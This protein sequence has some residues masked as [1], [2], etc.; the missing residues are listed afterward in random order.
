MN[1]KA[2]GLLGVLLGALLGA[3]GAG[4]AAAHDSGVEVRI[5]ARR[6]DDGRVE[7]ALRERGGE[8]I[9]PVRRY[10]PA[11][12]RGVWLH[13]SWIEAGAPATA[14]TLGAGPDWRSV[15]GTDD[16]TGDPRAEIYSRATRWAGSEYGVPELWM[17]CYRGEFDLW[18][19]WADIIAHDFYASEGRGRFSID[20]E[21]VQDF[22]WTESPGR[23]STF[24]VLPEWLAGQVAA[25]S[26][27]VFRIWD[28]EGLEYTAT[29]PTA[30]F[31]QASRVLTCRR[32]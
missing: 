30:G 5:E 29:F 11:D 6:L 17:R 23:E 21:D 31:A 27:A 32:E 12:G 18:I 3:L 9:L 10:F 4:L 1:A 16:L 20:G 22:R 13:S 25:G 15:V 24:A 14:A 8:R 2:A 28:Y 19:Y 7:F 26:R